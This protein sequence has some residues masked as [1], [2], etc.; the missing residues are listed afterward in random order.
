MKVGMISLGCDKNRVD[1]EKMLFCLRSA[2]YEIVDNEADA[3]II[4]INTCAFIESAK[5]E[6]I[7]AILDTAELKDRGLKYLIVTG[8]FATRYGEIADFPEVDRFVP[9]TDEDKI[10]DIVAEVAG[11]N[12]NPCEYGGRILTTPAHYAYLKIADGCDNKCTYCAIPSIRGKYKSTPIEDLVKEAEALSESGVRE[13]I[14]VAQ[15]T[16]NYGVDL[17]GKPSLTKLLTELV[18]LDFWKIRILYAYPELID[19]ELL[20]LINKEEKIAKYLDIPLQHADRE[21]LRRMNRR[22][23]TDLDEL[24]SHIRDKVDNIALRSSFICGFPFETEKEH[25]LLVDF[26]RNGV[27]YGGFFA[28]SPEED[29]PAYQWKNRADKRTVKRW[30]SE[31]EDAQTKF[32]MD[33]QKRFENKVV[34]V[35]Y[36]GIDYDKQCFYG[37]T[38][39]NAPE[40][41][42]LV[43]FTSDYPVEVGRVVKVLIDKADFHLYGKTI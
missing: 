42:T 30:I 23:K 39:Y 15:D 28:F 31:C 26:L 6:A 11:K 22:Q 33:R 2:G 12:T 37:R 18:K 8:C 4:I 13:L 43:F 36:E 16:T 3:E 25:V 24:L 14:L 9:V 5:K 10:A 19:D 38:E 21:I 17:Y 29:T 35:L 1:S 40:I 34:E 41:D 20:G 7:D 27:D 32:T